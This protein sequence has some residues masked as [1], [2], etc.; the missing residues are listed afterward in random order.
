MDHL[1]VNPDCALSGTKYCHLLNMGSC[2]RCTVREVEDKKSLMSDIDLYET[3]LP[4]GGVSRLFTEPVCQ[5]CKN[6]PKGKRAGYVM[7]DMAHPEPKR[8]QRWL[9]G[10]R[11]L[12]I[13]TMI[14]VQLGVCK[15]CRR[16]LML[17]DYLP[18]ICAILLGFPSLFLYGTGPVA[19]RLKDV[20]AA[21]P[22]LAWVATIVASVVLGKLLSALAVRQAGKRMIVDALAHPVLSEMVDKGWLPINFTGKRAHVLFSKSRVARGLGTAATEFEPEPVQRTWESVLKAAQSA[23]NGQ[24]S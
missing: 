11:T 19:D 7:L 15:K 18:P 3:L 2:E 1:P 12:R 6:E 16:T 14:P 13:G 8:T 10:K 22:A 21:L 4:Q 5:L 9:L 24:N 17:I 20:S 23:E